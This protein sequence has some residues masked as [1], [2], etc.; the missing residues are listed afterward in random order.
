MKCKICGAN[1]KKWYKNLFDDRHGFLGRFDILRCS[2]CGFGQTDPQIK[3]SEIGSL[4]SKYYPRQNLDLK[5]IKLKNYKLPSHIE[6]WRKGLLNS[7]HFLVEKGST[8]LDVGSGVGH[9]LLY[10]KNNGCQVYGIDPDK[11]AKKLAK[12]FKLN[13]HQGFIEDKPFRNK[14]FDYIIANQVLEHTN[15]PVSFLKECK[16][17]LKSNGVIIISFPNTDS[18]GRLV[19][20]KRWLH[21]HIPYHLN[22]F[23]KKSVKKLAKKAGLKITSIKTVTPNMWTSIQIRSLLQ[24]PVEGKRDGFWDG[25][26]SKDEGV[27]SKPSFRKFLKILEENNYLNRFID[28]LGFGESFVTTL[29]SSQ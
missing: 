17:R 8:V 2:N 28:Y 14:K 16:N 1:T 23:N 12:K 19:F 9:S 21:W 18:L 26:T 5:S 25:R 3:K 22:H 29:N 10:L 11:N 27:V 6:V 13:F 24:S 7:A 4:Y 15:E 20:K